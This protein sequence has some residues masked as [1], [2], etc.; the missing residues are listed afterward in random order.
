MPFGLANHCL[1]KLN[2]SLAI[3]VGGRLGRDNFGS[4]SGRTFFYQ[5]QDNIWI[6]DGP[7]LSIPREGHFCGTVIDPSTDQVHL[8]IAGGFGDSAGA[9]MLDSSEILAFDDP[10]NPDLYWT[11]GPQL[12]K[13]LTYARFVPI[14]SGSILVL[15]GGSG[16]DG[17]YNSELVVWTCSRIERGCSQRLLD[18]KWTN[19]KSNFIP[20][21]VKAD[22]SISNEDFDPTT[23]IAK[24]VTKCGS[25]IGAEFDNYV[26]SR[27]LCCRDGNICN[28][29]EGQCSRDSDCLGDLVCGCSNCKQEYFGVF[30]S[31]GNCCAVTKE[32][33]NISFSNELLP[34]QNESDYCVDD[35]P[36][37]KNIALCVGDC[38][39]DQSKH[40]YTCCVPINKTAL[41][42][43]TNTCTLAITGI[44]CLDYKMDGHYVRF[45]PSAGSTWS[46]LQV[47]NYHAKL[48]RET[49]TS[50]KRMS[51]LGD[52]HILDDINDPYHSNPTS[53]QPPGWVIQGIDYHLFHRVKQLAFANIFTLTNSTAS[54]FCNN[55][56]LGTFLALIFTF[57]EIQPPVNASVS[58]AP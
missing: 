37:S 4:V 14:S 29:G 9:P 7:A 19:A 49:L 47:G 36:C 52:Y 32:N 25:N 13:P 43:Q 58:C 50:R 33:C 28:I 55:Y 35:I 40:P 23:P 24:P 15:M 51:L 1:V 21:K 10:T 34:Y 27:E 31:G 54:W 11:L 44:S 48:F 17:D 57:S 12:P 6:G 5:I 20:I 46:Y 41:D 26:N 2:D 18:R 53:F 16:L 56:E 39:T 30:Q 45:L 38:K 8:V 42:N 22:C 3:A